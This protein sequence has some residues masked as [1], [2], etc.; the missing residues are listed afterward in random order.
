M[1]KKY[2]F[3]YLLMILTFSLLAINNTWSQSS[4]WDAVDVFC[5]NCDVFDEEHGPTEDQLD[6]GR[7]WL[8]NHDHDYGYIRVN[9]NGNG[10]YAVYHWSSSLGHGAY[11]YNYGFSGNCHYLI[12]CNGEGTIIEH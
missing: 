4:P 7:N 2:R 1:I 8:I 11:W 12:V 10:A 3:F 6:L 5:W 9:N